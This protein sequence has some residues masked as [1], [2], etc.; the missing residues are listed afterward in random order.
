MYV[1]SVCICLFL[2]GVRRP[3]SHLIL[4]VLLTSVV[5][6]VYCIYIHHSENRLYIHMGIDLPVPL[7]RGTMRKANTLWMYESVAAVLVNP[8]QLLASRLWAKKIWCIMI[9]AFLP[10]SGCGPLLMCLLSGTFFY[11]SVH[12]YYTCLICLSYIVNV[13]LL[14]S[15]PAKILFNALVATH[16]TFDLECLYVYS[17]TYS[18][19][20][21]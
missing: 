13:D 18:E 20:C 19:E 4:K 6:V 17:Y 10:M 5:F 14:T 15:T 1:S 12:L 2:M 16:A 8:S 9:L 7:H 11:R 21:C 3:L